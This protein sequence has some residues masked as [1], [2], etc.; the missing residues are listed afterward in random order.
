MSEGVEDTWL[1]VRLELP[2]SGAEEAEQF[3][4]EA[5]SPGLMTEDADDRR[6]VV[7]YFNDARPLEALRRYLGQAG[8]AEQAAITARWIRS[9]NWAEN[10]KEHFPP[11]AVAER[12]YVCPPWVQKVPPQRL[13]IIIDPGMAFGT[14]HHAT[15]RGCL[16][17]LERYLPPSC[18]AAL[19]I[20]TGSG[21]LAIALARLGVPRVVAVDTDPLAREAAAANVA[22]NDVGSAITVLGSIDEVTGGPFPMVVANLQLATLLDLET[23]FAALTCPEGLLIASGLLQQ[24][25]GTFAA[26]YKRWG[27][28]DR[29]V[30]AEW[31]S[32]VLRRPS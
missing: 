21:I 19:D 4:L 26:V 23:R 22:R 8:L 3:L 16:Q 6:C 27:E 17:L 28:G 25:R 7:A 29:I 5:G 15:T 24:D 14:G 1:E 10:W 31:V 20:G 30:D 32:L 13:A 2:A 9:E 18:P 12:L 11:V